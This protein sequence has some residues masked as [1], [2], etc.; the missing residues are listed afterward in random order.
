MFRADGHCGVHPDNKGASSSRL[1]FYCSVSK[2]RVAECFLLLLLSV[3]NKLLS[4]TITLS[5][6]CTLGLVSNCP[7]Q[8]LHAFPFF[9]LLWSKV[10]EV[11]TFGIQPRLLCQVQLLTSDP[12][13]E[14]E[15]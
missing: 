14:S 13:I 2:K 7:G 8:G 4:G 12:R 5:Y 6:H 11:D 1:C 15:G 10:L 3:S 9:L